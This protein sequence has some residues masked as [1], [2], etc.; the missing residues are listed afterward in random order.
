[1]GQFSWLD[2]VDN[3]TQILDNVERDVYF[4]V[5]E[6]FGG[7]HILETCY[8][9]YGRFGGYDAYDLVADWNR[10][11]LAENPDFELPVH[12]KKVSEFP[13]YKF[14]SDLNLTS[15]KVVEMAMENKCF[16]EYRWIGIELACYD[17]DNASLPYPIKITHDE[18][19]IYEEEGPSLSDPNQ[20]WKVDD[21]EYDGYWEEEAAEELE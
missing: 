19:A 17:D 7:G 2:C 15:D 13:W 3:E 5:P 20:G 6:E 11:Y 14:Y 12:Q 1:M 21:E 18:T 8:D 16:F 10:R 4:L 9:G